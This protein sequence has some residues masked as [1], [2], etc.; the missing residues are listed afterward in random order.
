MHKTLSNI[1]LAGSL[2]FAM[3]TSASASLFDF[4]TTN[5]GVTGGTYTSASMTVN[6]ITVNISAYTIDNDGLGTIN[7]KTQITAADSGV[8]V[9]SSGNNLGVVSSAGEGHNMDGG[10]GSRDS[11]PD[12]GLLFVFSQPVTLDYIN[13][14]SFYDLDGDDFNLT[15]DNQLVLLDYNANDTSPNVI[16]VPGQF[17]EYNFTG[18]SG[19][20]FLFWA[21]GNSD[22]FRIDRMRVSAV[23]LPAAFWLMASGL[24]G[25]I[26]FSKKSLIKS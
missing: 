22:S 15:V 21:D 25:V 8:Y 1:T 24:L 9:S 20:E 4:N 17:D 18:I 6:S 14:D 11:D 13:F 26:G 23:P 19:T 12:E 10:D 7:S 16:N 2:F 3:T 5:L